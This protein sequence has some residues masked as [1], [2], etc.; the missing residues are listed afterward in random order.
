MSRFAMYEL[1]PIGT[2]RNRS[3]YGKALVVI[4]KDLGNKY[5]YSYCEAVAMIDTDGIIHRIW[6]EWS[7]T[8][9]RHIRAFCA[10]FG[11]DPIRCKAEW[12]QLEP[13]FLCV[14]IN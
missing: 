3:F 12:D 10:E 13:E 2:Q 8:T 7:A 11:A 4:D 9:G 5:L 6:P 1:D 14:P